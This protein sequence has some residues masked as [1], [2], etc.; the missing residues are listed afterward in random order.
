MNYH[1][2]NKQLIFHL[3]LILTFCG[4]TDNQQQEQARPELLI[5]CGITMVEPVRQIA[6]IVE[7]EKNCMIKIIKGGSGNLYRILSVNQAGDLYLPGSES[8]IKKGQQDGIILETVTVGY[9]KAALVVAKNNP[10]AIAPS[11]SNV[12]D[13]KYRVV[14]G[15]PDSGSIGKETKLVLQQ[16]DI[17]QQALSNAIYLTTDSKD[18]TKAIKENTADLVINWQ[19]TAAWPQNIAAV[20]ALPIDEL[21]APKRKL[22]LSLLQYSEFPEIAKHFMQYSES[23]SGQAIFLKYGFGDQPS[24]SQSKGGK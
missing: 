11:L 19:A 5:Y 13:G 7:E 15:N 8:Y 20:T 21:Y 23:E 2:C 1:S 6:D 10:L 24:L 9:N 12:A 22:I 16:A 14:L 3:F 18:L 4:C 17:Y